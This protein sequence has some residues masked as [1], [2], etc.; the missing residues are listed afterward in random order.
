MWVKTDL[1]AL[2]ILGNRCWKSAGEQLMVG[3]VI[4]K[5]ETAGTGPKTG[6]K[7]VVGGGYCW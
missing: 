2:R 3:L 7:L 1:G 5:V 6:E 4:F